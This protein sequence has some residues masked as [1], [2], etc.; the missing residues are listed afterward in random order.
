MKEQARITKDKQE[1][2]MTGGNRNDSRKKNKT[3]KNYLQREN[4]N[5]SKIIKQATIL[6]NF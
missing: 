3:F 5:R 2:K 4:K 1:K 6:E